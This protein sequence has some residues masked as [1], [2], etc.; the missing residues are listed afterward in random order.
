[1]VRAAGQLVGRGHRTFL[2]FLAGRLHLRHAPNPAQA[3]LAMGEKAAQQGK[4]VQEIV[5]SYTYV[6]IWMSISISVILFN[7]W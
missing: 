3:R 6:L 1:M 5:K 2:L 4:V 7:K